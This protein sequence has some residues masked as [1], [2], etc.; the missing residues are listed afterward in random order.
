MKKRFVSAFLISF[1][2]GAMLV[3]QARASAGERI[4]T[5]R[6][7]I[8]DYKTMTRSEEETVRDIDRQII[9]TK[10]LLLQYE[11]D[12]GSEEQQIVRDNILSEHEKYEILAGTCAVYGPGI[13]I[14][15]DDGKRALYEG[16]DINNLIVHDIDILM[17]INELK[18]SG[19]EAIS[20]N[21]QRIVDSTSVN[22]SGWTIRINGV[23]YARP[24]TIKA[25][26][27]RRRMVNTLLSENG[28]GTSLREWGVI[29]TVETF[30]EVEVEA[31]GTARRLVYAAEAG[32]KE[33]E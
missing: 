17:I 30:D 2:V 6:K 26:G 21:G 33:K 10:M 14:T 16:E 20:V 1:I 27:N 25:I 4:Y 28:Y 13:E 15:V 22:C 18:R 23:T 9:E 3:I 32:G 12:D 8:E 29:F 11:S 7:A 5:S 31:Y 19:A 24:F